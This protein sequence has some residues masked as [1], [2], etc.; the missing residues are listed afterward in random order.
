MEI[1]L[2]DFFQGLVRNYHT[3]EL[4]HKSSSTMV[5]TRTLSFFDRVGTLLGYDVRMNFNRHTRSWFRHNE[6][7]PILVIDYDS[8]FKVN[9]RRFNKSSSNSGIAFAH[10]RNEVEMKNIV[11]GVKKS[12]SNWENSVEFL[13]I[14]DTSLFQKENPELHGNLFLGERDSTSIRA[15]KKLDV[16]G[17]FSASMYEN[18]L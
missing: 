8:S 15:F 7:V 13:V 1:I 6:S 2:L 18:T 10:P 11:R 14:I 12:Q 5:K 17:Q 4:N 9:L 16:D 3:F